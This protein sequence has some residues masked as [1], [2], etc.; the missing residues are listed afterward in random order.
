MPRGV[1]AALWNYLPGEAPE[2]GVS[3]DWPAEPGIADWPWSL[4]V[5]DDAPDEAS[6]LIPLLRLED[7]PDGAL[8]SFLHAPTLSAS[9][10]KSGMA[11]NLFPFMLVTSFLYK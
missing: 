2:P 7:D 4:D 6:P 11:R 3:P 8:E 5:S 10:R 1:V 9:R